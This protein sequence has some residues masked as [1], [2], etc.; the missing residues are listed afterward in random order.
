MK[1]TSGPGP[2]EPPDRLFDPGL[3]LERT[4]LAWRRTALA[5]LVGSMVATR[6]L[7]EL[8]GPWMLLPAS[9]GI[10]IALT[11]LVLA[12]RRYRIHHARLVGH[13]GNQMLD[14]GGLQAITAAF[15]LCSGMICLVVVLFL[16]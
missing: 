15:V 13:E 11:L 2:L 8:G 10:G 4:A 12:H 6:I 3:Q 16:A 1:H 9:I 7:P 14:S 5:L